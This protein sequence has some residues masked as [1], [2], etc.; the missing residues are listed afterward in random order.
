MAPKNCGSSVWNLLH[1]TIPAPR[2]LMNL[3][4]IFYA[5]RVSV[6]VTCLCPKFQVIGYIFSLV[7]AITPKVTPSYFD[8]TLL[9]NTTLAQVALYLNTSCSLPLHKLHFT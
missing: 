5:Q 2:I 1:V 4:A 7:I 8:I 3:Q 6:L 9:E